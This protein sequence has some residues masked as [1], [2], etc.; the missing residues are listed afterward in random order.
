MAEPCIAQC[1]DSAVDKDTKLEHKFPFLI[2][3][4]SKTKRH[5]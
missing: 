2:L 3:Q 5:K 1:Y 4:S